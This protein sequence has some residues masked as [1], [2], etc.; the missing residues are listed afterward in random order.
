MS[1]WIVSISFPS[2]FIVFSFFSLIFC[3]DEVVISSSLSDLLDTYIVSPFLRLFLVIH[4]FGREI[5]W[6][7]CPAFTSFL[8]SI[9]SPSRVKYILIVLVVL[10]VR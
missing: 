10:Y 7:V 3:S 9:L 4:S 2:I 8:G 1:L 6:L 5:V